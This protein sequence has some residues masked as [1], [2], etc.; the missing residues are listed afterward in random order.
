MSTITVVI[1]TLGVRSSLNDVVNTMHSQTRQIDIVRVMTGHDTFYEK[2]MHAV[3]ECTTDYIAF[4]DDDAMMPL[5]W[6]EALSSRLDVDQDLGYVGGSAIPFVDAM[7]SPKEV[8]IA[9]V[10][11]SYLGSFRMADRSQLSDESKRGEHG[12]TGIGVYRTNV[13]KD[14]LF[15]H[16]ARVPRSAWEIFVFD[17]IRMRGMK[18][19]YESMGS[20]YHKPRNNL[21][22]FFITTF[23]SG[24]GRINFYKT[25]RKAL[26]HSPYTMIPSVFLLYIL[27]I[28]ITH[29]YIPLVAYGTAMLI[30]WASQANH[31]RGASNLWYPVATFI[32]HIGYG[33]G[34][35]R[36]LFS[37][38]R[39]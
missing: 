18:T 27:T 9:A 10:Q 4:V 23:R 15:E 32:G 26:A 14:I 30:S 25:D 5:V 19:G 2:M 13:L 29:Y 22:E 6:V 11:S 24:V 36:G 8:A 31:L 16:N 3:A 1:P 37:N 20:F 7:S 39:W 35:L 12:L 38:D 21:K 17:R 28:P 33:L 34:F